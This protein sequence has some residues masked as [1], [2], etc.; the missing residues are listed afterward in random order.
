MSSKFAGQK[1]MSYET[2]DYYRGGSIVGGYQS[3]ETWT[4][5]AKVDETNKYKKEVSK[6]PAYTQE[7]LIKN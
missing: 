1:V 7:D 5:N 6:L 4:E 3:W 2:C